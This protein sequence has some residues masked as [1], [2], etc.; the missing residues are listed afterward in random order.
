MADKDDLLTLSLKDLKEDLRHLDSKFNAMHG[1]L[2]RNTTVLEEHER[3]STMSEKR[4]NVLEH[5]DQTRENSDS[6]VKGFF[7]YTGIIFSTLL[8]LA[9]L[10]HYIIV[11]FLEK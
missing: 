1:I 9:A 3:R 5:K 11:P 2:I 4:I 10:F 8:T 6:K 7:F